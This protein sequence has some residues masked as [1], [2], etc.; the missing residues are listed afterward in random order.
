[1]AAKSNK[2]ELST[3]QKYDNSEVAGHK[4]VDENEKTFVNFIWCKHK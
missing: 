2:I 1:M 4:A 3:V